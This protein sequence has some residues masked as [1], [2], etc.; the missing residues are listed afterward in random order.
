ME[1]AEKNWDKIILVDDNP[2]NLRSGKNVLSAS[3]EVYTAPSAAKMF[4]LLGEIRP[5]LILLDIVMP[6]MDGYEAI[7]ILKSN[8]ADKNIP[9]IFLTAQGETANELEGLSLGAIDYITK[10]FVPQLL[11][12][13][14]EVHLLVEKQ[15]KK[16]EKQQVELKNFNE[17][18]QQMVEEKT[19]KVLELNDTFGRYLS[20]DIVKQLL[21]SP[22]GLALGGQKQ[23]ITVLMTDIRGFTL[24]SEKMNGVD[25]VTM[26]NQYFGIMTE[27]IQQY[28]GTIIEFIGDAILAI[29]GAPI[30]DETHADKAVCCAIS[31]QKAMS[32]V[33]EWNREHRFPAL[34]MGIGINTG[35]VI[36]G[37]IGSPKAMKYNV[38][39]KNV[40]LASR[41]ET[42]TTGGQVML[43]EN[44]YRCVKA[45]LTV[46]QTMQVQPK[47][48][49]DT[50]SIYE[51]SGIG[52]PHN[53]TLPKDKAHQKKLDK[54]EQIQCYLV[55]DKAIDTHSLSC[56]LY[57]MSE[58]EALI[59]AKERALNVFDNIKLVWR[60]QEVLAKVT[61]EK[62]GEKGADIYWV[63]FTTDAKQLYAEV[64]R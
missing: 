43:S 23:D 25:L 9:V 34:E 15:K 46:E 32:Q 39:G 55:K 41:V 17:N 29:F 30:A 45:E 31:M 44:T 38:I 11:L 27:I 42:Y 6:E 16:L 8:P 62:S 13:R 59:V 21:E 2:S 3:Y 51:I 47:G 10:P 64:F 35:E 24:M 48:I 63:R 54:A 14:I 7:K 33:N 56:L 57:S 58:K 19:Q 20:E 4:E 28:T 50:I 60:K 40:N 37:N 22:D 1:N 36:V 61:G 18:L 53:L 52:A 5:A 49:P 26:L 12:K